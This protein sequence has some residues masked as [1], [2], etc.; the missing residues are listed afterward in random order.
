MQK[1][2][3]EKNIK[4]FLEGQSK[5][6]GR[7]PDERYASFDYCF[8]YFQTFREKNKIKE[9]ANTENIQNS[10]LH[11]AFYLASWGMF[12]GSSFLLEKS[13]RHFIPLIKEISIFDRKI[14]EIDANNYTEE[15]IKL[16]LEFKERISK[17]LGGDKKPSDILSTKIMLG[18]FG[19]VPAFDEFF[20]KGFGCS[21][22]GK[23][24]L[25]KISEFY[26]KHKNDI[27]KFKIYTF[28]FLTGKE[29]KRSYTNAKIIDMVGFIGG[30]IK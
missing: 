28:N 29:T 10:C 7:H 23:K 25:K 20:K 12:R 6:K 19:N 30:Q 14:W 9:L 11:L 24:S 16:L 26:Q 5:N 13:S 22:F 8:N 17:L 18:V 4:K 21:T 1:N 27:D 15:N 3:I 2:N